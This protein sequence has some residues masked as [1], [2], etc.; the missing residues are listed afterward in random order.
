L[1]IEDTHLVDDRVGARPV[2]LILA[3][4]ADKV[5]RLKPQNLIAGLPLASTVNIA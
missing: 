5:V 2:Y 4:G 1:T 3:M